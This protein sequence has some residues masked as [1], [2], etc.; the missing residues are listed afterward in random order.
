VACRACGTLRHHP[1]TAVDEPAVLYGDHYAYRQVA[2]AQRFR[3]A[4]AD[5]DRLVRPHLPPPPAPRRLLEVG[6]SY[7]YLLAL[8][9][10]RSGCT[11]VGCELDPATAQAARDELGLQVHAGRLEAVAADLPA[12]FDLILM[13]DLIE[14]LADPH[15]MLTAAC[16][17]LAPGG[18]LVIET[19]RVGCRPH[20]LAGRDWIGLLPHHPVLYTRRGLTLLLQRHGLE[21]RDGP[22]PPD[23]LLGPHAWRRY[24]LQVLLRRLVVEA[25]GAGLLRALRRSRPPDPTAA[26]TSLGAAWAAARATLPPSRPP[27]P[28][29]RPGDALTVVA[30]PAGVSAA[31]GAGAGAPPPR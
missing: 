22:H 15:P 19:P 20:R 5:H 26:P 2:H 1:L 16:E 18:A 8:A 17:L 28:A 27:R 29:R 3:E 24:G 12:P 14:H 9:Q 30:R 31:P 23:P 11:A 10:E 6:C 13:L 21:P 4:L 7:G 25:G